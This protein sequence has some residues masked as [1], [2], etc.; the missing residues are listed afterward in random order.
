MKIID[1]EVV[2]LHVM[3]F[4]SVCVESHSCRFW[5]SKSSNIIE[6]KYSNLNSIVIINCNS[7]RGK[8]KKKLKKMYWYCG[9]LFVSEFIFI[10]VTPEH[11]QGKKLIYSL[12]REYHSVYV[13][14]VWQ[15][16]NSSLFVIV[17]WQHFNDTFSTQKK[18]Y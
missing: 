13:R 7:T 6:F 5:Q 1:N 16:T 15:N 9:R 4:Q 17:Y 10:F 18:K 14:F 3:L 11:Y 2:I 12:K 8:K